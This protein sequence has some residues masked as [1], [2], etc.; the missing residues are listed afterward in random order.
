MFVSKKLRK[1][2]KNY[3]MRKAK[4]TKIFKLY[5]HIEP[6]KQDKTKKP[7]KEIHTRTHKHKI[8]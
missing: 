3:Q 2:A 4:S 6:H 1:H 8:N 7:K 5:L